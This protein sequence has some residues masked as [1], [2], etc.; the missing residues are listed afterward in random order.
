MRAHTRDYRCLF[1]GLILTI[2]MQ[3][4]VVNLDVSQTH[5]DTNFHLILLFY[6]SHQV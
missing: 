5:F 4:R 1:S 6:F 3:P 2:I